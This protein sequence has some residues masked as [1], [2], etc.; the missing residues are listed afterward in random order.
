MMHIQ[1]SLRLI[2]TLLACTA[3][4]LALAQQQQVVLKGDAG[5]TDYD[6]HKIRLYR[7]SEMPGK[8][9][10]LEATVK[11]GKF[12]IIAPFTGLGHYVMMSEYES[13][14]NGS[15]AP[16]LLLVERPDTIHIQA[17]MGSLAQSTTSGS[18]PQK[19]IEAY[20]NEQRR[21]NEP[22]LQA[23]R[24]KYGAE[25]FDNPRKYTN[26]PIFQEL[27]K[28]YE[29]EVYPRNEKIGN[30][31]L[32]EFIERYPES[33]AVAFLLKRSSFPVEKRVELYNKLGITAQNSPYGKGLKI[34]NETELKSAVG[35]MVAN[36]EVP[37]KT[38]E[39]LSLTQLLNGKKYLYIDFWA[40]WCG[41]CMAEIPNLKKAYDRYKDKGLEIWGIS[42]DASRDK[43]LAA[44]ESKHPNWP[45]AWEGGMEEEKKPS[46]VK[47]SVPFLPSTYLLD[48]E[49]KI[50]AK[51]VRGEELDKLLKELL[52]N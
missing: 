1:Q 19:T 23:L 32:I 36:F 37:N 9:L 18:E 24:D 34:N 5:S 29:Q 43:W 7:Y 33:V 13:K 12:E 47:F 20:Y 42:T 35:R 41:P 26:D 45:Q 50:I 39:Q 10:K 2:F 28:V 46:K 11:D 27:S 52:A 21:R 4:T 44:L 8:D 3:V 22:F 14:T 40:S 48:A 16:Y 17:N 51:N 30:E 38:G 6:G 31:L 25:R 15:Y 49:G